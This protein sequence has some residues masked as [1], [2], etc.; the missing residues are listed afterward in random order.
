ML[1][2]RSAGAVVYREENGELK[3]LILK[4]RFGHWDFPKGSIEEGESELD[5]VKREIAEETGFEQV[6]IIEGFKEKIGYYYRA[7]GNLVYKTV[8]YFL[9]ETKHKEVKLSQE[10]VDYAWISVDEALKYIKHKNSI[11]I[12]NKAYR[13]LKNKVKERSEKG[14]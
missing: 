14:N 6:K 1:H 4:Y 8:T 11:S 13:F 9:A 10:H 5:T 7:K 12:L 3:F 2:K